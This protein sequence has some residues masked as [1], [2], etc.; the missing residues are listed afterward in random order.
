MQA[1]ILLAQKVDQTDADWFHLIPRPLPGPGPIRIVYFGNYT[2]S[3]RL[4]YSEHS[5]VRV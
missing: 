1:D 3:K 5:Y 4:V 2:P